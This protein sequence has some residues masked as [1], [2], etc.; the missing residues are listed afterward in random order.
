MHPATKAS[1]ASVVC[2]CCLLVGPVAIYRAVYNVGHTIVRN[3]KGYLDRGRTIPEVI[4]QNSRCEQAAELGKRIS[5]LDLKGETRKGSPPAKPALPPPQS[6]TSHPIDSVPTHP[7][8][9][10]GVD[11]GVALQPPE[12]PDK[13]STT[14]ALP[15]HAS[16]STPTSE[17]P[18]P[19]PSQ[20]KAA[21][22]A[23]TFL[24]RQYDTAVQEIRERLGNENVL[25][26][27]KFTLIGAIMWVLFSLFNRDKGSGMAFERFVQKRRVAVFFV[28]ALLC[29]AIVDTRLRFNAKVIESLGDWVWCVEIYKRATVSSDASLP[30][31]WEHFLHL[32][33]LMGS[34]PI[35]RYLCHL[36]TAIMY[37]VTLYL[38]VVMPR[39][40]NRSAKRMIT[41]GGGLFFLLLLFVSVSYEPLKLYDRT[42]KP[43]PFF[44]GGLPSILVGILFAWVGTR[45]LRRG[46]QSRFAHTS[47]FV[48]TA[49]N[50]DLLEARVQFAC[51]HHPEALLDEVERTSGVRKEHARRILDLL[52]RSTRDTRV[53]YSE[54]DGWSVDNA[55]D[56]SPLDQLRGLG[57]GMR[58]WFRKRDQEFDEA[59]NKEERRRKA[60]RSLPRIRDSMLNWSDT[61]AEQCEEKLWQAHFKKV[62][63]T[64]ESKDISPIEPSPVSTPPGPHT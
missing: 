16:T 5:K 52:K 8:D 49:D 40:V 51:Y 50:E 24:D 18:K 41:T 28:A 31:Y 21:L 64:D 56:A 27:L 10:P 59:A 6:Q 17:E 4:E 43:L 39:T 15:L 62:D 48:L 11:S 44:D 12:L 30:Q 22:T 55:V 54:K 45:T 57:R 38:F 32:Q 7:P 33:L 29:S 34:Y 37:A 42:G 53:D 63:G 23:E 26:A 35:L 58:R 9:K 20:D 47:A 36:L 13:T 46:L 3:D 2:A 19:N 61:E 25:F 1:C 60:L 14:P